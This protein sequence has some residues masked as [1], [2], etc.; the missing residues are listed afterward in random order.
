MQLVE[1]IQRPKRV[2]AGM[3]THKGRSLDTTYKAVKSIAPQVDE[4]H[5]YFNDHDKLPIW[6]SEFENMKAYLG[7]DHSGDLGARAKF[8]GHRKPC[9][10]LVV[11]DDNEYSPSFVKG[12]SKWLDRYNGKS[13]VCCHGHIMKGFPIDG[14]IKKNIWIGWNGWK[15]KKPIQLHFGNTSSLMFDSSKVNIDLSLVSNDQFHTR[16]DA[17]F[18]VMLM[19]KKIPVY[20]VPMSSAPFRQIKD[21]QQSNVALHKRNG[22]LDPSRDYVNQALKPSEWISL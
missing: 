3:A 11:D 1:D 4:L 2:I 8:F 14:F 21:T 9:R 7:K 12:L 10:Y 5:V 20:V 18:G 22:K 13:A 19:K 16:V 6:I 17:P 15:S